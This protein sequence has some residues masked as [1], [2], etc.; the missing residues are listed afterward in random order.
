MFNEGGQVDRSFAAIPRG[1][2]GGGG[3]GQQQLEPRSYVDPV[4]GRTFTDPGPPI[5]G[6][7]FFGTGKSGSEQLNEFIAQREAGE[8]TASEQAAADR[9]TQ[10]ATNESQFQTNRTNAYNTALQNT[11]R[12]F[13]L[14]GLDPNQY[15]ESDI[16]P[17]LAGIQSSIQDLDPN[18]S[19]AFSPDLGNT[20]ISDLTGGA[21]TSALN[22]LNSI[23]TPTYAQSNLPSS[24][25]SPYIDQIVSEQFDPLNAQLTNAQKRGI[26]NDT[27]YSA[28]LNT[29]GQKQTGARS[30]V[31]SLGENI[32]NEERGS[33]NDYINSARGA[34]NATTLNSQ[35]DPGAYTSGAQ[36][37]IAS[38]VGNFGGALRNAVGST[39]FASL[40]DLLNAGGAVQGAV[41]T[42][43]LDASGGVPKA[44]AAPGIIDELAKRPRGL[45]NTGAF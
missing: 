39:Q 5:P 32:L 7:G 30:T 11:I 6:G 18:P 4:T 31:Q 2:K 20:I 25:A 41:N 43:P 33:L 28:A 14:A 38:D 13:Q 44:G 27:G 8:K 10:A 9:Q 21:R 36:S 1:G 37:M 3:G 19:A 15:M 23:F 34:A 40:S 35:F 17:R 24:I 26:L 29:L 12:Q 16:K 22:R 42:S 45:G